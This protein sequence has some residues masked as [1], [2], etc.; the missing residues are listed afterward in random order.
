[1]S[2][3][4]ALTVLDQAAT[5]EDG[6]ATKTLENMDSAAG[7]KFP[8]T[9]NER[10]QIRN[11]IAGARTVTYTYT[12]RGRTTTKVLNLAANEETILGPFNP[13]IF[14]S[15]AGDAEDTTHVWLTSSNS[16]GDVKARVIREAPGLAGR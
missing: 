11:S 7:N 4:T 2:A 16:T 14:N 6:A 15:H 8:N 3:R 13:A 12:E 10:V 1:M 5:P 9:G